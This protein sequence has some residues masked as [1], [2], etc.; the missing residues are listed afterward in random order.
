M[1]I[2]QIQ[3]LKGRDANQKK[4]LIES[5]TE[6]VSTSINADQSKIKVL[7]NEIPAENWGTGGV[8]KQEERR[9]LY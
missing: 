2:V 3:L 9:D 5:V 8:T 4:K 6:A 1:P 7:L